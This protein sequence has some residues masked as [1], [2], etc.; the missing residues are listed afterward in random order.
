M[1]DLKEN[2][3]AQNDHGEKKVRAT[4]QISEYDFFVSANGTVGGDLLTADETDELGSLK[5][6]LEKDQRLS[7][8]LPD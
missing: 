4:E 1:A 5:G 2:K 7:F 3:S 8:F 6:A